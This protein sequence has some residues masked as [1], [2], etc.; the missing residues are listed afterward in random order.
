MERSAEDRKLSVSEGECLGELE[1]KVTGGAWDSQPLPSLG[2]QMLSLNFCLSGII[3][4]FPST[5]KDSFAT[6]RILI[7]TLSF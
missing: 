4:I 7:D 3:L 6:F 5:L 1:E 2:V